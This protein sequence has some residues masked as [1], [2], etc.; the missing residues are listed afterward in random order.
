MYER[1]VELVK[2]DD[3]AGLKFFLRWERD[4]RSYLHHRNN[5]GLTLLHQACL[6]GKKNV[7][8]ALVECGCDIE[9]RSSVGWT[10][11]HA[12]ALS[13]NFEVVSYLVNSCASNVVAVDDMGCKPM[14]LTLEPKIT[15]LLR[16]KTEDFAAKTAEEAQNYRRISQ[17]VLP[18]IL[19]DKQ[20]SYTA[21]A[22]ITRRRSGLPQR[23][24]SDTNFLQYVRFRED[25]ADRLS[26]PGDITANR[27]KRYQ[28]TKV[29]KTK[30]RTSERDSGIYEDFPDFRDLTTKD[31]LSKKLREK[32]FVSRRG[33]SS[34]V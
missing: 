24:E 29:T 7:V 3:S 1:L 22:T 17:T 32:K 15:K 11:L 30:E 9:G 6:L 25:E 20:R 28:A 8:N 31:D 23:V 12:G 16:E 21:P 27:E 10:A 13:G 4:R 33:R 5:D 18:A 14:D 19:N 34:I 2:D 26:L